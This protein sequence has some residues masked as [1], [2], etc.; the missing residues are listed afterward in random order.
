MTVTIFHNPA[1]GTS[2]NTLALLQAAGTAPVVVEYLKTPPSGTELL[3]L[4]R[5]AGL[6]LRDILRRKGTPYEELGLD[7][8]ALG[9]AELLAAIAAHPILINRPIVVTP[10]GVA[11]CRPSDAVQDLL[12]EVP[13]L[14]LLKEE[15]AP[16]LKDTALPGSDPGLAAALSAAG[17][18]VDDLALPGR[19]FFAFHTLEGALAGYGGFELAAKDMLLRSVVVPEA[20]RGQKIGRNIVPLL[21][22]RAF[23]TGAR[24]GWLLT[25]SAAPFFAG[26]GFKPKDRAEAP[27]A[28]LATRQAAALCPASATL[29]S[30][31][32]GF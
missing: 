32:L 17:L 29:M 12:D 6:E 2:R 16:F 10:K 18:P 30:R 7:N 22:Y 1:C 8:P 9:E 24:Q 4:A 31:K 11:L 27:A 21:L 25:E 13:P 26:L 15:G 19:S 14:T 20:A 3:D 28:I 23:R 5:R